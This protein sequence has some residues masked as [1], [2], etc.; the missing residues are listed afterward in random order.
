LLRKVGFENWAL[1]LLGLALPCS[2]RA[3]AHSSLRSRALSRY[4]KAALI[5]FILRSLC[6]LRNVH[7]VHILLAQS[8][9]RS[10]IAI[11]PSRCAQLRFA[12]LIARRC[13]PI[14]LSTYLATLCSLFAP[15]IISL[16]SCLFAT[17]IRYSCIAALNNRTVFASL[18]PCH[19]AALTPCT[20]WSLSLLFL[21]IAPRCSALVAPHKVSLVH[22]LR[23]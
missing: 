10:V 4:A 13:A 15:L 19:F 12:S 5:L 11:T 3:C 23:S 1:W 17:L 2:S 6:S 9:L 18:C 20:C 7:Y 21:L 16:R 22:S 8:S 14:E